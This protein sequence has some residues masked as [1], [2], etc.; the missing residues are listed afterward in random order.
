LPAHYTGTMDTGNCTLAGPGTVPG[1]M[2]NGSKPK[3]LATYYPTNKQP[4]TDFILA[5]VSHILCLVERH[6]GGI[7]YKKLQKTTGKANRHPMAPTFSA[8][9]LPAPVL[10][11]MLFACDPFSGRQRP[12][13]RLSPSLQGLWPPARWTASANGYESDKQ[14][15]M[16]VLADYF[17]GREGRQ[18]QGQRVT[19]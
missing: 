10:C 12:Y 2:A 16:G 1:T 14:V 8:V 13:L 9:S 15:Q 19:R 18:G 17:V 11:P 4:K 7:E 5:Q 3:Y 6:S